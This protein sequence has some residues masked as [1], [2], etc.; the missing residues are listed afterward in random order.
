MNEKLIINTNLL[1]KESEF[2]TKSCAVEKAI[3]VSHAEFDDLKRRPLQD[4]DLIVENTDIMY[5][6]SDDIYHCLMIYDEEQ[7]DGLLIEAEG[8][9][10]AR[11]A[12]YIPNAKLLYENHI[13]TH[14]QELKFYCPVE[15]TRIEDDRGVED[16]GIIPFDEA[17]AY[18]SNINSFISNFTMPEEKERGLMHWYN[19]SAPVNQKVRSAF[20]SVEE[21]NGELMG[22]ITAQ[23]YGKFTAE[24]LEDFRAY[25]SGQLSDGVGE[26]LEQRPI[27]TPDGEIYVSFWNS[28]EWF[29]QTEEEI[30]GSQSEDMSEEPD[31]GMTM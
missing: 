16:Y 18:K 9:S 25:C 12:Q 7:G 3:A 15:L 8:S 1:R 4:N 29:L 21:R 30:N 5:R 2:K 17:T 13:Q 6:D 24:E 20:M 19:S 10:Y 23:V 22:V 26:S 27:K 28:D 11:Y 14:L 31:M